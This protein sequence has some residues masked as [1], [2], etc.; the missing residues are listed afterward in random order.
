MCSELL[1]VIAPMGTAVAGAL[2]VA[3]SSPGRHTF[4]GLWLPMTLGLQAEG[5][6]IV[7]HELGPGGMHS[8]AAGW[9]MQLSLVGSEDPIVPLP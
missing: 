5:A 8:P 2:H 9:S 6:G 3:V 4:P 7:H 1:L